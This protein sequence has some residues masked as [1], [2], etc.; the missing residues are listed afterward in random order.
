[1]DET[2][3]SERITELRLARNVSEYQMSLELG[4]SKGYIQGITSG[5]CLPS[6]KQLFNIADYFHLTVAEFFDDGRHDSPVVLEAIQTL[7]RLSDED[8]V[9]ILELLHRIAQPDIMAAAA[10]FSGHR[11]RASRYGRASGGMPV[12]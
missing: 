3:I 11:Q 10:G 1:M 7:R 12:D 9:L 4:Q 8:A 5:K 6:I 2:F